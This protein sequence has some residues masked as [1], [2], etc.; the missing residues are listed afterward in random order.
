MRLSSVDFPEPLG[1]MTPRTSPS[2]TLKLTWL[3]ART[4][5]N[6]FETSVDLEKRHG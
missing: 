1:P 6:D 4:P 5:P 2:L 3:T